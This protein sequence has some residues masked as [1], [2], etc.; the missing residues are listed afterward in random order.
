M[1][2][3]S[4][5][6]SF[7]AGCCVMN[8]TA[9]LPKTLTPDQIQQFRDEGYVIVRELFDSNEVAAM[10]AEL[11]R[12]QEAGLLRNV[13]TNGDGV[14]PSGQ[15]ANL[16]I[17]PLSPKSDLF[18]ALPFSEKVRNTVADLI[19]PE[20]HLQLDQ[21][22]LKPPRHGA[23]TN[24]HQ[25]NAYF[26][27]PDPLQ[28]VGMWVALHDAHVANGT[29]HVVPRAFDRQ[30]AHRRDEGSDHHIRCDIN[31]SED[32][33]VPVEMAAG[34]ALFFN[35]GVPHCTRKNETDQARAGLALHFVHT[36][37][38]EQTRAGKPVRPCLSGKAYTGGESEY[39]QKL[40]GEWEAKVSQQA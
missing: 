16:Q 33:V 35:Y 26:G 36:Q 18:R 15:K 10:Q 14:T 24:W 37:Y 40:E 6:E 25:D 30:L 12:L 31:E 22:F 21:I 9:S 5:T 19:G 8:D 23:G 17:C 39:G 1:I 20:F 28:G 4:Q 3:E 38:L 32:E 34:G 27:C 7:G 11:G 2:R 13:A 29:M